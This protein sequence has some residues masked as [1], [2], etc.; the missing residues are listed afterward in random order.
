MANTD[1]EEL[2]RRAMAAHFR[3]G[4]TQQPNARASG[5]HKVGSL[6]YVVLRSGGEIL[7]VYR[8]R[9]DGVL[10]GLKRWPAALDEY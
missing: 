9:N 7:S 3:A 4:G 5:V 6:K 1:D 2:M 8:V 10:K